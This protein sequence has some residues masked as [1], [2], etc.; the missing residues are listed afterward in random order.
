MCLSGI[1]NS[2]HCEELLVDASST[3]AAVFVTYELL[4]QKVKNTC[5]VSLFHIQG[6]LHRLKKYSIH[7][8]LAVYRAILNN[9]IVYETNCNEKLACKI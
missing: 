1:L 8:K 4:L 2:Q 6:W 9:P 3:I 5:A 7:A